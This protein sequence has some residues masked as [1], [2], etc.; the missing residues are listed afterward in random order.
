MSFMGNSFNVCCS[1]S[2]HGWCWLDGR[3]RFSLLLLYDGRKWFFLLFHCPP[4]PAIVFMDIVGILK[5][6]S[7]WLL[8]LVAFIMMD[9]FGLVMTRISLWLF[10][11]VG[12]VSWVSHAFFYIHRVLMMIVCIVYW[13]YF[14]NDS[15]CMDDYSLYRVST[16]LFLMICHVLMMT[17]CVVY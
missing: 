12:V 13:Q 7:L 16:I 11:H 10:G 1:C 2:S 14:F 5:V 17:I 4:I 15:S 8:Y 6:T 3:C 9:V